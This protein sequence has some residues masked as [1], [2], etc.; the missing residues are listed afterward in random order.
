MSD[1]IESAAEYLSMSV[2]TFVEH[3][4]DA[5]EAEQADYEERL[6][7][8]YMIDAETLKSKE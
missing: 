7:L 4:G 3:Y 8:E 5:D 2:A 6:E 1:S